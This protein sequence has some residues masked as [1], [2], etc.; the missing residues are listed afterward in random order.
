MEDDLGRRSGIIGKTPSR[1]SHIVRHL[2]TPFAQ[3]IETAEIMLDHIITPFLIDGEIPAYPGY[4][5]FD[6][7]IQDRIFG[8]VPAGYGWQQA[9]FRVLIGGA[10]RP[11]P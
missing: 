9:A 7:R 1:R 2:E 3:D 5:L 11:H 6:R 10:E 8:I 4:I